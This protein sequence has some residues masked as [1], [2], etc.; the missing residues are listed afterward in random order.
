[1]KAMTYK[2]TIFAIKTVKGYANETCCSY[3]NQ[4]PGTVEQ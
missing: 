1:M 2:S 4:P 3:F